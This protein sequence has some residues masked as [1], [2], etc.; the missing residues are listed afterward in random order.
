[1]F[2]PITGT[3]QDKYTS[4]P[5]AASTTITQGMALAFTNGYLR[6]VATG[7]PSA[8]KEARY[9]AMES[10]VTAGGQNPLLKVVRTDGVTFIADS[11]ATADASKVGLKVDFINS[12]TIDPTSTTNKSFFIENTYGVLANKQYKGQFCVA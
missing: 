1:M 2:Q 12:N 10:K 7:T 11:N 5:M 4:L 8:D 9:V 3:E 6:P